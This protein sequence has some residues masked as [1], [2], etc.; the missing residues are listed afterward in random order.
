M[1]II[2]IRF[3]RGRRVLLTRSWGFGWSRRNNRSNVDL[4]NKI[5][6][7]QKG[8]AHIVFQIL[9]INWNEDLIH[10]SFMLSMESAISHEGL[11][12]ITNMECS[13][14]CFY[15][16][17]RKCSSKYIALIFLF[18]PTV[19]SRLVFWQKCNLSRRKN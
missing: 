15:F 2:I 11:W 4:W 17:N 8:E 14:D 3:K 10:I 6:Q 12:S 9:W 18:I 7:I 19:Y 1:K 5:F 16:G 13:Y